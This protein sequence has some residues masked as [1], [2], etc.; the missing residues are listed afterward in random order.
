MGTAADRN[1]SSMQKL[2]ELIIYISGKF[3]SEPA[4]GDTKL[5]KILFFSDYVAFGKFGETITGENYTKQ[6]FG[7]VC[8]RLLIARKEMI[9]KDVVVIRRPTIDGLQTR[10]IPKREANLTIFDGEQIAI[11]DEICELFRRDDAK[12]I[13]EFSH[14]FQGWRKT[15]TGDVIPMETFFLP[16]EQ[17]SEVS[18]HELAVLKELEKTYG[19]HPASGEAS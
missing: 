4:A 12:T 16:A 7:P 8:Q 6:E 18:D 17:R 15:R 11:V 14:K 13:S 19:R 1:R 2:K 5:N 10:T 3:E 9:P